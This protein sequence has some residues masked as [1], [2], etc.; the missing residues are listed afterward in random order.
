[1]LS[2]SSNRSSQS[3]AFSKPVS[4]SFRPPVTLST[5][6]PLSVPSTHEG[7]WFLGG[8]KGPFSM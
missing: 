5:P 3:L 2:I 7:V 1:M 6:Y 4:V 8:R